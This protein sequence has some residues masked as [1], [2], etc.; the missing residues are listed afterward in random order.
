MK[1]DVF[2]LVKENAKNTGKRMKMVEQYRPDSITHLAQIEKTPDLKAV[3][4]TS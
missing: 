1:V 3:L 4:I 2:V